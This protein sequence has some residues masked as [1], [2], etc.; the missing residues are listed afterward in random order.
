MDRP[1]YQ[2]GVLITWCEL[3]TRRKPR[4]SDVPTREFILHLN[5]THQFVLERVDDSHLL[6]DSRCGPSRR[7]SWA[8][9]ALLTSRVLCAVVSSKLCRQVRQEMHAAFEKNVY[10][11]D[12]K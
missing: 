6:I 3:S 2:A 12:A 8:P 10:E 7:V 4:C 1:I 11:P 5:D 9:A